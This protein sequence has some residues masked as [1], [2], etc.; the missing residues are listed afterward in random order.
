[1]TATVIITGNAKEG[2]KIRFASGNG[3]K[4]FCEA[5]ESGECDVVELAV[6]QITKRWRRPK[7]AA[8]TKAVQDGGGD[9]KPRKGKAAGGGKK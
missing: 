1:M 2:R 4:E 9:G 6:L 5:L 8:E 7:A 3:R